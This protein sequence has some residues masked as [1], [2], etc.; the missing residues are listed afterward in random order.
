MLSIVQGNKTFTNRTKKTNYT[1][2]SR[3][4][5]SKLCFSKSLF[6]FFISFFLLS[7][8]WMSTSSSP[9]KSF[10]HE[11]AASSVSFTTFSFAFAF[12]FLFFF[13]FVFLFLSLFIFRYSITL[14]KW[15]KPTT[16]RCYS[17]PLSNKLQPRPDHQ[18]CLNF[19]NSLKSFFMI[20]LNVLKILHVLALKKFYNSNGFGSEIMQTLNMTYHF[21]MEQC[22]QGMG[23]LSWYW[24][25]A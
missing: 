16:S 23:N 6:Y 12:A 13:L 8:R 17:L 1:Q 10:K 25:K 15:T 20:R 4:S 24:Q 5:N 19:Q 21:P 3:M 2:N 11:S 14:L 7:F 9:P 22:S 18:L